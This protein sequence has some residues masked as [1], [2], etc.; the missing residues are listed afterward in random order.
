MVLSMMN[1]QIPWEGK[2]LALQNVYDI[3]SRNATILHWMILP[4][5]KKVFVAC[6]HYY[7]T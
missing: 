3:C 6:I 2:V 1:A 4:T 5:Q 7:E